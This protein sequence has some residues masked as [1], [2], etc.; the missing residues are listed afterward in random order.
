MPNFEFS[1][2]SIQPTPQQFNPTIVEIIGNYR[3]KVDVEQKLVQRVPLLAGDNLGSAFFS[4]VLTEPVVE[5]IEPEAPEVLPEAVL[6]VAQE[7]PKPKSSFF[8]RRAYHLVA[9]FCTVVFV[10]GGVLVAYPLY[11][12]LQYHLSPKLTQPAQATQASV[13]EEPISQSN[14]LT[15][16]KIGVKTAILEGPDL[17]TLDKKEGVWHQRGAL[18]SNFVLAGHR[19][20]YL[21]PNTST[22]YNLDKLEVGDTIVIDWYK[23]RYVYTVSEKKVVPE[24]ASE[25]LEP[26]NKRQLTIYTCNDKKETERVVVTA[27]PMQ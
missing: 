16:P 10:A 19:W 26:G 22:F 7:Q 23:R 8:S 27:L 20:R 4:L 17:S 2:G 21:P 6:P 9:I 3:Y 13:N 5:V 15:I 14:V 18:D 12:A 25:L 24:T 11:P 1:L